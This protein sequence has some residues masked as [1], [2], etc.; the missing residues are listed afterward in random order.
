MTMELI[1]EVEDAGD[2]TERGPT[3]STQFNLVMPVVISVFLWVICRMLLD[4][5]TYAYVGGFVDGAF[6]MFFVRAAAVIVQHYR[7]EG[8]VQLADARRGLMIGLVVGAVAAVAAAAVIV[9]MAMR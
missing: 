5:A 7:R 3:T 9:F 2:R 8:G 4:Q 1:N 6:A